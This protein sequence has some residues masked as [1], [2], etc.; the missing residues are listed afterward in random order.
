[1][2]SAESFSRSSASCATCDDQAFSLRRVYSKSRLRGL[3]RGPQGLQ[4]AHGSQGLASGPAA[5]G[6]RVRRGL[7]LPD[8]LLRAPPL[9]AGRDAGPAPPALISPPRVPQVP[10]AL[11]PPPRPG[12]C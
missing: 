6:G 2:A 1:M 10:P 11:A 5:R 12:S 8:R 3:A 7:P 9:A 4:A